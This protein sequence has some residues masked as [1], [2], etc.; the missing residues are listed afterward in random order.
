MFAH[1]P[2]IIA[3]K[4]RKEQV[5]A[6]LLEAELG[7]V[8]FTDPDFDTDDFGTFTGEVPRRLDPISAAREKCL[9][10]ME[11]NQCDLGIASEGSFGPHP[12]AFFINA[13]DEWLIFIDARHQLEIVVREI[14]TETNFNQ[15][16]INNRQSLMDFALASG[17]P[18][19]GLILR[20]HSHTESEI[21]KGITE[22]SS[23]LSIFLQ[24]QDKGQSI[25]AETDMRACF[26]PSRMKVIGA[27]TQKL[28]EKIKSRCP[29]C[30][31]PGFGITQAVRGLPC[32][33]CTRP[34]GQLLHFQYECQ[35][36]QYL[37]L[38]TPPQRPTSA[39][40]MHCEF[41]NP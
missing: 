15:A 25:T 28:I 23:L 2:L 7:V 10:A 13:D 3:T 30:H 5:I 17:F 11:R 16:A 20:G 38:V 21:H 19:H 35:H 40:P 22:L 18:G 39:D 33:W 14:S 1:R 4:H 6:P 9:R 37:T 31:L 26:N 34:T 8:C 36:C 41:C 32:R 29:Q 27:A 12:Q 24:M